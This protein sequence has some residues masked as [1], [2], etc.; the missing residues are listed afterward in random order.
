MM[1]IVI[2][3]A[4]LLISFGILA[5]AQSL[6]DFL[7]FLQGLGSQNQPRQQQRQSYQAS[8]GSYQRQP[9]N[10]YR[11]YQ[12]QRS[13]QSQPSSFAFPSFLSNFN[14]QPQQRSSSSSSF[15]FPGFSSSSNNNHPQQQTFPFSSFSS[16]SNNPQQQTFPFSISSIGNTAS[17]LW[18]GQGG[19]NI[20]NSVIL[21]RSGFGSGS[22]SSNGR[23]KNGFPSYNSLD[24]PSNSFSRNA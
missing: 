10:N 24:Y 21:S 8:P 18:A 15:A 12:N 2:H 5:E 20:A 1:K 6:F 17:N 22:K 19:E 13:R 7:P 11:G 4:M 14:Q 3:V 16:S 23:S 9:Q